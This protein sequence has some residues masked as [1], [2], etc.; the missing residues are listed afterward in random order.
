M[1]IPFQTLKAAQAAA[2]L[3]RE[4]GGQMSRLRLLVLL[5]IA[6]RE[7][8]VETLRPITG[9]RLAAVD[10]GPIPASTYDLLQ[11][12][13]AE[14]PIWDQFIEQV[15]PQEHRLIRD[16]GVG[17]LSKYEIE[18]LRKVADAR[19]DKNEYDI[20][21]ETQ[22]FEEWKRNKPPAHGRLWIPLDDLLS[23]LNLQESK[24][25]IEQAIA[26]DAAFDEALAMA[27]RQSREHVAAGH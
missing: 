3:L 10:H 22:E 20:A 11:R 27:R 12:Q 16:P 1:I 23:A 21:L 26:D 18:K 15:G 17:E 4:H 9:D 14:A 5:D 8:M 13:H 2:V 25:R 6:S 24:Q 7:S 19:R